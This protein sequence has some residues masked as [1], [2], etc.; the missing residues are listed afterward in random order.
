LRLGLL[1]GTFNP[2]HLGHLVCAMEARDQLG[3]DEVALLPVNVAPHKE[4]PD[5]PGPAV[6][7]ELCELAAADEPGLGV[8]HEEVRRA[9]P[10]YTVDTL[11][12]LHEAAPGDQLT[13]IV[14]ADQ[15]LGL[16]AWRD[17]ETILTFA[18]IAVAHRGDVSRDAILDA[19]AGL[20]GAVEQLVFF[21][22]PRLDISSSM[23]RARVAAGRPIRHL[24][25]A[26]VAERIGELGL[27]R[28][29]V[30]A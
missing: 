4:V 9:G 25:P 24:V 17:P 6:R 23:I 11:R 27:Y 15:A 12:T 7:V 29:E 3:L 19:V 26:A 21:D 13:F 16:P 8:R 18:R 30:T 14:G 10:S 22:M 2:P 20:T 1:G 5:D 28:A